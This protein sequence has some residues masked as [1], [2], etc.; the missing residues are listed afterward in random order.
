MNTTSEFNAI[1]MIIIAVGT[2]AEFW[3]KKAWEFYKFKN[4]WIKIITL[5]VF[6]VIKLSRSFLIITHQS[7]P[8]NILLYL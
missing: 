3:L 7:H 8:K 2:I 5:K 1:I 6:L 4:L